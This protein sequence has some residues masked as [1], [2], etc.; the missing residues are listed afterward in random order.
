MKAML[1]RRSTVGELSGP[2]P[3]VRRTA[4]PPETGADQMLVAPPRLD[5]W[6]IERPSGENTGSSLKTDAGSD[7]TRRGVPEPLASVTSISPATPPCPW[8][9]TISLPSGDQLGARM[10]G[11]RPEGDTRSRTSEP[12]ARAVAST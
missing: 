7:E 10:D 3:L 4:A 8:T 12:S 5:E 9:N 6:M 11:V 2:G 1:P